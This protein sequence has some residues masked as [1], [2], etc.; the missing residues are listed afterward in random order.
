VWKPLD[1]RYK[2]RFLPRQRINVQGK[3]LLDGRPG[4]SNKE[5]NAYLDYQSVKEQEIKAK[6]EARIVSQGGFGQSRNRGISGI[7]GSINK[8][9]EEEEA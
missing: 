9:I 2:I 6:E 4:W 5:I 3:K 7:L 8:R 1:R